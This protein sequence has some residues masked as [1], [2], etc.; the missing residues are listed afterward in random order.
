MI[1]NIS[2]FRVGTDNVTPTERADMFMGISPGD[3]TNLWYIDEGS[4]AVV[5]D[6]GTGSDN[7]TADANTSWEVDNRP[8]KLVL[9]VDGTDEDALVRTT[10]TVTDN[11]FS[12]A[13]LQNN[14]M[15]YMEYHTISVNGTQVQYIDWEYND[16]TFSDNSTYGNDAS[17]TF[18]TTSSDPDVS[19]VLA[20]F[21]P[22]AEAQ[23]PAYVLADAPAFIDAGALTGNV[24]GVFTTL[25]P[26]G[27]FP[28]AGVITAVANATS[29]PPQLPLLIIA[30]FV[31]LACSLTVS[32]TMRRYGSG[33]LTPK[34][35]TITVAMG[36][37]I[38]LGN[39]GIDD[40]MLY[41]FLVVAVALAL[42]SRQTTWA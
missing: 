41:A 32:A 12:W 27:T 31:I 15:P 24:T 2:N 23:A 7:G 5:I 16:T 18:R 42:A 28:L 21:L 40:W 3:E 17:P 14:A 9:E 26:A 38:G 30:V 37:F 19:A 35:I 20:S 33:S 25:P 29:T 8:C 1:G 11:D 39:F 6:Y 22:V 4:G 10:P 36:V 34:I 13:F